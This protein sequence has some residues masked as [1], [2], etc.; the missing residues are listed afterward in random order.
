MLYH[1]SYKW[2]VP[3]K[4]R[5]LG[6]AWISSN[7]GPV[8][9]TIQ[10]RLVCVGRL[11]W[12]DGLLRTR[13]LSF[14]DMTRGKALSSFWIS[15]FFIFFFCSI[16]VF[17]YSFFSCGLFSHHGS[18]PNDPTTGLGFDLLDRFSCRSFLH[19]IFPLCL[20]IVLFSKRRSGIVF[21]HEKRIFFHLQ[22]TLLSLPTTFTLFSILVLFVG[23]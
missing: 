17:L 15:F 2:I 23:D 5:R 21:S 9:D 22:F 11:D 13:T 1:Y 7:K 3:M 20:F 10:Q 19:N 14:W 6:H 12:T 8:S 16:C 18:R 4:R